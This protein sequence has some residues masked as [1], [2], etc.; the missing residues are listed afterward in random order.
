MSTDAN[1]NPVGALADPPHA[2]AILSAISS[3]DIETLSS[4]L[5]Q[6]ESDPE[7]LYPS[8]PRE[9]MILRAAAGNHHR[10]LSYL[11]QRSPSRDDVTNP[12]LLRCCASHIECYKV[13]IAAHPHALAFGFGHMASD[14]FAYAVLTEDFDLMRYIANEPSLDIDLNQS[15]VYHRPALE[16]AAQRRS[17][18]LLRCLLTECAPGALR[19]QG[20]DAI[21]GAIKGNN[22]DNLRCL[23][24]HAPEGRKAV[25]DGWPL[26]EDEYAHQLERRREMCWDVPHLHYAVTVGN[27]DAVRILLDAGADHDLLD[28][29]GRKAEFG[30]LICPTLL[31]GKKSDKFLRCIIM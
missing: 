28:G 20:T 22:S 4:L 2:Q 18:R 16:W 25:A 19:V 29:S 9:S 21:R 14:I 7:V 12:S 24:D 15:E 10:A 30:K 31:R 5:A 17:T 6:T 3:S 8:P 23:L 13:L 27:Q 11:L 26:K 1:G